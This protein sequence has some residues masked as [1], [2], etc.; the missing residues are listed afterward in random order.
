MSPQMMSKSGRSL[1]TV[2]ARRRDS[3]FAESPQHPSL[4]CPAAGPPTTRPGCTVAAAT[5]ALPPPPLLL[6]PAGFSSSPPPQSHWAANPLGPVRVA[7][8]PRPRR[9]ALSHPPPSTAGQAPSAPRRA[10]APS[11]APVWPGRPGRAHADERPLRLLLL[12]IP[13]RDGVLAHVDGR[14]GGPCAKGGRRGDAILVTLGAPAAAPGRRRQ[15][16][17]VRCSCGP[18]TQ[19]E[20]TAPSS[21]PGV[22]GSRRSAA[23]RGLRWDSQRLQSLGA[24]STASWQTWGRARVVDHHDHVAHKLFKRRDVERSLRRQCGRA[25]RGDGPQLQAALPQLKR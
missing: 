17:V 13:R 6:P 7:G 15:Q 5:A 4:R 22:L 11:R 1:V 18:G 2:R 16:V 10:P 14:A 23:W 20:P 21:F 8:S 9:S 24:L 19:Q 3:V 12:C 25:C